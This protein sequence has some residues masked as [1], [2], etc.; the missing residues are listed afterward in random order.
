MHRPDPAAVSRLA[1]RSGAQGT[2]ALAGAAR[3]GTMEPVTHATPP[4]IFALCAA[5]AVLLAACGSSASPEVEA[6][7][8]RGEL[9][10][11]H[12]LYDAQSG[13]DAAS[14]RALALAVLEREAAQED[15]R[16]SEQAFAALRA[17]GTAAE[18]ALQALGAERDARVRAR[19]HELLALL[20][21]G[22]ARAALRAELSRE[23]P[24][25][26][27]EAAALSALDPDDAE[28]AARLRAALESPSLPVRRSAVARL[29]RA[30]E[31]ETTGDALARAAKHDPDRGVRLAALRALARQGAVGIAAL[32]RRLGDAD[33]EFRAA[34]AVALAAAA[35]EIARVRIAPWLDAPS[36]EA[37]E[38][39]HALLAADRAAAPAEARALLAKA[40][41]HEDAM[42]R[43]R[44]A[45]ALMSLRDP[46]LEGVALE[47]ARLDPS[48]AVRMCL[49]LALSPAHPARRALLQALTSDADT[50]AAEA[51]AELARHGD[52][53]ALATLEQL[54]RAP[55]PE[56]RRAA[57]RALARDLRRAHEARM[58]MRDEDASVR[59]AAAGAILSSELPRG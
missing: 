48:R 18:P 44:A 57:A 56:T 41:V 27:F 15:V 43:G 26:A 9:D 16:R 49:A 50:T 51:A 28:D 39:A 12:R 32:D 1:G 47:R 53:Q 54:L 4:R 21:D 10:L 23:P 24:D 58:A 7:L 14:L 55:R 38:G 37:V 3:S 36:F 35:P 29:A 8:R 6:A 25:P 5:C 30:P 11:A 52:A 22:S 42:L 31:A 46:G 17:A 45:V 34:A 33:A 40:L 2:R 20:G 19:A 59:I 13:R